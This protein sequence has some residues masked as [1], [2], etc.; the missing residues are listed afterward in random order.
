MK[1]K[2]KYAQIILSHFSWSFSSSV[3]LIFP[4]KIVLTSPSTVSS[5]CIKH[6]PSR[7]S[8]GYLLFVYLMSC[9][10]EIVNPQTVLKDAKDFILVS[11][12]NVV[13]FTFL[14]TAFGV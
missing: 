13:C 11:G 10:Q 4:L 14:C 2:V 8:R 3:S 5:Y 9:Y 7:H 6:P 12:V 1:I